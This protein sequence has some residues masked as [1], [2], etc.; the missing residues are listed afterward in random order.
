MLLFLQ[1]NA[2][3]G[4]VPERAPNSQETLRKRDPVSFGIQRV[5]V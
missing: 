4:A 3:V 1:W 2:A 5:G